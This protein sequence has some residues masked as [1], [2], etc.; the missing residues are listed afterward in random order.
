MQADAAEHF[1]IIEAQVLRVHCDPRIVVPGTQHI[2]P[3][4]WSPLI[5]NFRHYFGLSRELGH[6]FRS[7]TRRPTP[8]T[9]RP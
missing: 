4:V 1:R 8:G 5:Y 7:E 2:D 9:T 3:A 6:S